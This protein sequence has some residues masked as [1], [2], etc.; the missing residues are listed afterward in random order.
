MIEGKEVVVTL[1]LFK[2]PDEKFTS[3]RALII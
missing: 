2:W 3:L 1:F